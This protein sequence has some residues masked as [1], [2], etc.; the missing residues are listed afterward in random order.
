MRSYCSLYVDAGYLMSAAS[1]R[2]TGTSLRSATE[3]DVPALLAALTEQVERASGLPL[4]RIHWYDAGTRQGAPSGNQK[5]IATIPRVKVRLGRVG[6]NGEQKGVDLKLALDLITQSRN[7]VAEVVYLV[8]GDDDLSEAVEEAQHHGVQVMA[9]GVPD[10]DGNAINVSRHLAMTVDQL[11][12]IDACVIDDHVKRSAAAVLREVAAA[13]HLHDE[14][15][16]DDQ[17]SV[18]DEPGAGAVA[19]GSADADRAAAIDLTVG[20]GQTGDDGLEAAPDHAEGRSPA[21]SAASAAEEPAPQAPS[22]LLLSQLRPV[23]PRVRPVEVRSQ[24]TYSTS[25]GQ[26]VVHYRPVLDDRVMAGIEEVVDTVFVNWW[27][28]ASDHSKAELQRAKPS[29]PAEIDR[30]LL[31]DLSR[32]LDQYDIPQD[33]RVVMRDAFWDKLDSL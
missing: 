4:L 25:T 23:V 24:P 31:S 12:V 2:V 15:H 26:G 21:A 1:T 5:D 13:G 19:G 6:Y 14:D 7:R 10:A 22:P 33:W 28:G 11:L 16:S 32:R 30:T 29:I 9:L 20:A 3:M 17:Q 18:G 8:S 27:R